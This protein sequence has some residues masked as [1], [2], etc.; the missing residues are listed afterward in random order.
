MKAKELMVGDYVMFD[1]SPC[2]IEEISAKGWIHILD[3][4]NKTR[5]SLT[6]DYILGIIEP[7][8]LTPE[9]LVKNGLET[10]EDGRIFGE[11]FDEDDS[12]DLEITFDDKT[13]VIWWSYNWDE[14]RIIKLS[15]VHELQHALRL[16][17]I[18]KE[19]IL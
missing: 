2:I 1:D 14:Y 9:I 19:I 12:R 15:Y 6:S 17:G 18:E 5:V 13:G 11:C 7:I 8:P 4:G 3:V 10:E 16:C